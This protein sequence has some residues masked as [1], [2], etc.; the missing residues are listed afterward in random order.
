MG[1]N[2]E[3]VP[4]WTSLSF[5]NKEPLIYQQYMKRKMYS[6]SLNQDVYEMIPL[7]KPVGIPGSFWGGNLS[8]TNK[9]YYVPYTMSTS[10]WYYVDLDETRD[11]YVNRN[12]ENYTGDTI[13][14]VAYTGGVMDENGDIYFIPFK[15]AYVYNYLHYI[16][17]NDELKIIEITHKTLVNGAYVGGALGINGVIKNRIYMAPLY[18]GSVQEWHYIYNGELYDYDP[19]FTLSIGLHGSYMGAVCSQEGKIYFIPF[20]QSTANEW[21]YIRTDGAIQSYSNT[22]GI[23][24]SGAF[25]GGVL[26]PDG[27][28]FLIPSLNTSD[29]WWYIDSSDDTIHTYEGV[30]INSRDYSGGVLGPNGKIYLIPHNRA[31]NTTWHYIDVTGKKPEVV[32]YSHNILAVRYAYCGG[33]LAPNG[34]IYLVPHEQATVN[35]WH[36][37][38]TQATEGINETVATSPFYNKF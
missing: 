24:T 17:S 33:V 1:V 13:S 34:R 23:V 19:G 35:K 4:D 31:T 6:G 10:N 18:Q 11:Y 21:H 20:G 27:K 36:F 22:T 38:D 14:D 32:A 8:T 28:I 26:A 30:S 3:Y 9:I 7:K 12:V 25:C 29:K 16:S 37:I 15:Q 2:R 5:D